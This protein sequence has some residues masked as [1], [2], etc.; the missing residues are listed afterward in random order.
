[1]QALENRKYT[2]ASDKTGDKYNAVRCYYFDIL[3]SPQLEIRF[4]WRWGRDVPFSSLDT[5]ITLARE[6]WLTFIARIKTQL[7]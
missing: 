1:M 3:I 2:I 4:E 5:C 6:T 7:N